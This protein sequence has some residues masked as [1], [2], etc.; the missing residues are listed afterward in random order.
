MKRC[1][2]T[3]DKPSSNTDVDVISPP[4]LD[5]TKGEEEGPVEFEAVVEV[6]PEITIAG[7]KGLRV[8]IE[9]PVVTDEHVEQRLDGLRAQFAERVE[10]DRAI[11]DGD[12]VTMNIA[13]T[14]QDEPVEG[15]TA[16]DYVYE[17]GAN[18]VVDNFAGEIDGAK[19]GDTLTFTAEHPEEDEDDDLEFE[20][21]IVKVEERVLPE[22][23][24]D[25]AKEASEFETAEALL[26]DT[27][28]NLDQARRQQ[29]QME[30]A[31]KTTEALAQLVDI[32]PPEALVQDQVQRQVQDMAIRMAQ[33]GIQFE[34]FLEMTGQ[35]MGT[36]TENMQEPAT[37][38]AKVDLALR[39]VL[40]AEDM[41]LSDD[42]FQAELDESAAAMGQSGEELRA[43]FEENGQ[44]SAVKT[45]IL[46]QKA[47]D[48]LIESVEIVDEDGNTI[49]AADL[50]PVTE[51]ADAVGDT[52]AEEDTGTD[53][54]ADAEA[55]T[56]E[57]ETDDADDAGEATEGDES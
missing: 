44:I 30:V 2:S 35:D 9:S 16:E 47:L 23:T 56:G 38:A 51:D 20:V 25:F 7:Y 14:Y 5:I 19:A 28:S 45:D 54:E 21:E 24:D 13:T 50:E 52:D 48:M 57:A 1:P 29:A 37:E 26:A 41:E 42:E 12:Y 22:V 11:E 34:Q 10:T 27:R 17:A 31:Q 39:A 46:K 8:E 4:D 3:T 40:V 18:F 49:D 33:Q 15:L 6:R 36:I 32:D 53:A 43:A 55:A